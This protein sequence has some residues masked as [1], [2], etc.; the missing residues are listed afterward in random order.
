M[1]KYSEGGQR[2]LGWLEKGNASRCHVLLCRPHKLFKVTTRYS[3][4]DAAS[5]VSMDTLSLNVCDWE[6]PLCQLL[7][8]ER[9]IA[10]Y[11]VWA[12]FIMQQGY[13]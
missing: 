5:E 2:D 7:R 12:A 4:L 11:G 3:W 13:P 10:E 8:A 9:K 1:I 6:C